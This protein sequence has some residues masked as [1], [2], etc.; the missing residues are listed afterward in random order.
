M[1]G[2]CGGCKRLLGRLRVGVAMA[3]EVEVEEVQ[4]DLIESD[5]I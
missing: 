3:V 1:I 2:A 4:F 5:L